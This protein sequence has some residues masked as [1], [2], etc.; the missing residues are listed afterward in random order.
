M[1]AV[2]A[3]SQVT[4]NTSRQYNTMQASNSPYIC[5]LIQSPAVDFSFLLAT[6]QPVT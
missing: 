4:L 3:C 2:G 5:I 6:G 1:R